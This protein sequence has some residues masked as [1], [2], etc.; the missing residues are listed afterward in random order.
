M[1]SYRLDVG[2]VHGAGPGNI[3]GAIANEAGL[4]GYY[5]QRLKIHDE[6][7]TVDLPQGMPRD[8]FQRLKKARVAGRPLDICRVSPVR[9]RA[10]HDHDRRKTKAPR[11]SK[12]PHAKA[13][14][15]T[16]D[17]STARKPRKAFRSKDKKTGGTDRQPGFRIK[18]GR[19]K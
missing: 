19:R 12:R 4:D 8:V 15:H 6:Y 2:L 7:S 16:A 14:A 17:A 1:E 13:T 5:I 9:D 11:S 10:T 3:V 18:K